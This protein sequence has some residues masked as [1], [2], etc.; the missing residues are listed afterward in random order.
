[1]DYTTKLRKIAQNFVKERVLPHIP[2][3]V[4]YFIALSGSVGYGFADSLSDIEL[5]IFVENEEAKERIRDIVN[6]TRSYKGYE[7]SAGITGWPVEALL[8]KKFK[9]DTEMNPYLFYELKNSY[10]LADPFGIFKAMRR[11]LGFYSKKDKIRIIRGLFLQMAELGFHIASKAIKRGKSTEAG[12]GYYGGVEAL[13]RLAH[14]LNNEFFPSTKHLTSMFYTL[15][16]K[17]GIDSFLDE[18]KDL[19]LKERIELFNEFGRM[20]ARQYLVGSYIT[21]EEYRHPWQW[22]HF[23]EKYVFYPTLPKY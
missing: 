6:N 10:P 11:N 16:R 2:S 21:E 9:V 13:L 3:G 20:F 8:E 12:I 23:P 14:I 5:E 18:Q 19:R 22:I 4:S 17:F 1:M 15:P 7:I